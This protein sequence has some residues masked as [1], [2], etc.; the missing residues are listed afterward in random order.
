MRRSDV[1][2]FSLL[3]FE[4]YGRTRRFPFATPFLRIL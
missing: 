4:A 2:S 3:V 1:H